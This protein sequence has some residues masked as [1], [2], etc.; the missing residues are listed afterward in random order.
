MNGV[1]AVGGAWQLSDLE[2]Y[3]VVE[4]EPMRITYRGATITTAALPSAGGIGLTQ[5]FGML[6]HLTPAGVSDA[7]SAHTIAEVL[8]RVFRDHRRAGVCVVRF[9]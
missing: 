7:E 6:E 3:R 4:R 5:A 8:R 9:R 2:N 1:N